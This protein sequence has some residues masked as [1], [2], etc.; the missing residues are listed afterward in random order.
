MPINKKE[1]FHSGYIAIIGRPNVGKST[2]LNRILGEKIVITS[3]KPQTTRYK[4]IGIKSVPNGQLIFL[5][6]PGIHKAKKVMNKIMVEASLSSID[7]ADIIIFMIEADKDF[8][9]LDLFIIEKL[10]QKAKDK[11]TFLVIN[12]IDRIKKPFLLPLIKKGA[13][14]YNFEAIYPICAI[15]GEGV[16]ELLSDVIDKL[17]VGPPYYPDDMITD[18]S[19]RFLIAEIIREKIFML[20]YEEIPYSTMVDVV[21]FDEK[22]KKGLVHIVADIYVERRSQKG[23]IIGKNGEMLKKIGTLARKEIEEL[24]HK[25]VFLE[26]FVNVTPN[27]TKD[28][29]ILKEFRKEIGI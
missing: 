7:D 19:E 10:K 1:E 3:P 5:D 13:E 23:I 15:T 6:T 28:K 24:L 11:K 27:W 17:P 14:K 9:P 26:L 2:L 12:K 18:K 21:M 4:I 20:T 16:E 8:H 22:E 29:R 25:K